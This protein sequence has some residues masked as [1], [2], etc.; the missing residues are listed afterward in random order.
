MPV[1]TSRPPAPLRPDTSARRDAGLIAVSVA[2]A[3]AVYYSTAESVTA[4]TGATVALSTAAGMHARMAMSRVR[5]AI[6]VAGAAALVAALGAPP[7]LV[8]VL[9][10][11][12]LA[13][14]ELITRR[15]Q[16]S[17]I[18]TVSSWVA[19]IAGALSL[20]G[21]AAAA[22]RPEGAVLR[23]AIAAAI[24]GFL[25]APLML[26]FAPLAEGLFG[27][28][29]RLTMSDWLSYDHPLLQRLS[30]DAPG[31]FQHS[32]NVGVL[33]D[34]AA[35]AIGADRL[36]ARVGGLYHD[37]GKTLAPQFFV[38]N[39]SGGNPH[40]DLAPS[41]SARIIRAHVSDGVD[42]VN[43]HDMGERIVDF[44]REHHGTGEMRLLREKAAAGGDAD[45]DETYRYAGPRPQSRETGLVMIADQLEATARSEPPAD[46][47]AC[48]ALVRDTIER[49]RRE[50]QLDE[51]GLS[52]SN[53]AA[54]GQAF[55]RA[56]HAMYH[57]RMSYPP[58]DAGT[59]QTPRRRL[60]FPGRPRRG[61]AM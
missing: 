24:G 16:R 53:L 36:L 44:V 13:G 41:A 11:A 35:G 49:I 58:S 40:D 51:S 39:Q 28:V 32:V 45:P 21:V 5:A 42:L 12:G 46:T 57:R 33:A 47:A 10:V 30:S 29:T 52:A 18:L 6:Q 55:T 59:S 17:A 14:A 26:T 31:T 4:A 38:E 20:S 15:P 43:R 50:Q 19:A 37:V 27:H 9:L 61:V 1:L 23:E 54:A 60:L 2:L 22:V 48:E 3:G 25:S 56:L 34:A 7:R 8:G